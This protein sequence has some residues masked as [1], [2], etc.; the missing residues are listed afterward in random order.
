MIQ[1][2]LLDASTPG[3]AEHIQPQAAEWDFL[4]SLPP[5]GRRRAAPLKFASRTPRK[6]SSPPVAV[7]ESTR[8][9]VPEAESE[10]GVE[11][12]SRVRPGAGRALALCGGVAP[13]P[14]S[15]SAAAKGGGGCGAAFGAGRRP[16]VRQRAS[17]DFGP[18]ARS[19]G[20][21]TAPLGHGLL[22]QHPWPAQAHR[23]RARLPDRAPAI[24]ARP[25][26]CGQLGKEPG[27]HTPLTQPMK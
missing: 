13:L 5:S 8:R 6:G 26:A 2:W 16:P 18:A 21:R 15:L 22:L 3:G 10:A 25:G 24:C 9:E 4:R 11:E 27:D 14:L 23:E 12:G 7:P 19:L 17:G 1:L 20:T